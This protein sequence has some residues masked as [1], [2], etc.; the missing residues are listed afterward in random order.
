MKTLLGKRVR[1]DRAFR[2]HPLKEG[3][4]FRRGGD[5][6]TFATIALSITVVVAWVGT[7]ALVTTVLLSM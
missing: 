6:N 4:D 7:V 2:A 1:N 5:V 3:A